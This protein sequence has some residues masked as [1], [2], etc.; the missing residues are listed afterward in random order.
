MCLDN[1]IL[2]QDYL[3]DSGAFKANKFVKHI[4]ETHQLMRF[5]GTNAHHN[6]EVDERA[7]Q[8]I[9][10]MARSMIL[11]ASMHW[12][13]GIDASLCTQSVTYA[14]HVYNTTTKDGVCPA[15]IF[16][17][18]AVPRHR[19]MDL[20]VWGCP[21]YVLDPKIQQGQ[22]LPRW[23]PKSKRGIFLGLS[24]YH[25]SEV[26]L[27]L[28]LGTGSITTQFHVVFDY[29]FTTVPSIERENE[30]PEHWEELW[31]NN[32]IRRR[33][34]QAVNYKYRWKVSDCQICICMSSTSRGL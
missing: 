26:P 4:H 6:N 5:C 27:V 8:T 7:I 22:K 29:L 28:N 24:Q 31:S 3:T 13:D 19:L 20:N 9:S 1:G 11:H 30:A 10:N 18:S 2:V 32:S 25:E 17:G 33:R 14:T 16:F 23:A 21:V 15:D 34:T 12:K